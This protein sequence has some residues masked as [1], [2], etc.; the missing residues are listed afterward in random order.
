MN[1]SDLTSVKPHLLRAWLGW[2]T[3]N[4][5]TPLLVVQA[6]PYVGLPATVLAA[7][8]QR[9][10]QPL[11]FSLSSQVAAKIGFTSQSIYF[12][13]LFPGQRQVSTVE[14][15]TAGWRALRV[16][17]TN[18]RFDLS[19]A[20]HLAGTRRPDAMPWPGGTGG[21]ILPAPPAEAPHSPQSMAQSE[22]VPRKPSLVWDNPATKMGR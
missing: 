2:C 13:T 22:D 7:A 10:G 11:V 15:P 3:A 18:W 12:T 19:F 17:E 5:L 9:P 14:I 16:A 20:E 4:Q 21:L 6:L 1:P 8:S